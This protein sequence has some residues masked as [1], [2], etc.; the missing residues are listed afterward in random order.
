MQSQQAD[1]SSFFSINNTSFHEQIEETRKL[2]RRS[3]HKRMP[4]SSSSS[5]SKILHAATTSTTSK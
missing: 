3:P 5:Q 4:S 2:G 1:Q